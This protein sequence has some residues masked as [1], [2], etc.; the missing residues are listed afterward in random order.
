MVQSRTEVWTQ[1]SPELDP[2]PVQSSQSLPDQIHSPVR[3]SQSEKDQ[4]THLDLSEPVW[5]KTKY[6]L[7]FDQIKF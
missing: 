6:R 3:D 1:T 2:S 5:T 7:L 4:W